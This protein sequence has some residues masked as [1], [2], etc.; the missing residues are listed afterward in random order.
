MPDLTSIFQNLFQENSRNRF[1]LPN[2]F[3]EPDNTDLTNV[4]MDWFDEQVQDQPVPKDIGKDLNKI[5][6][7]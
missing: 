5:F 6:Q 7:F 4:D 1:Q 3:Q 2:I